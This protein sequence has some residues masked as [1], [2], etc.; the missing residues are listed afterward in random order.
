M[1]IE[2]PTPELETV[3]VGQIEKAVVNFLRGLQSITTA[4][5]AG[6]LQMEEPAFRALL[7]R[8][9][10]PIERFSS[11]IYRIPLASFEALK[12]ESLLKRKP[13]NK[14]KVTSAL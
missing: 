13:R 5:A 2:I 14:K 8:K 6:L 3:I 11:K 9:G 12:R 1:K 4:T 10:I 7:R